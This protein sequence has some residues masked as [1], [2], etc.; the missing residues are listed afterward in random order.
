MTRID[1]G[2]PAEISWVNRPY[3]DEP[4][5]SQVEEYCEDFTLREA[6]LFAIGCLDARRCKSVTVRCDGRTYNMFEIEEL[7][8][9]RYFPMDEPLRDDA[10]T[11]LG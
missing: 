2:K 9:S 7:F 1:Y 11:V 5:G 3:W 6:V 10:G 8:R 4:G